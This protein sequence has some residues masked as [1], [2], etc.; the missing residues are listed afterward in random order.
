MAARDWFKRKTKPAERDIGSLEE[1]ASY[2]NQF[3]LDGNTYSLTGVG[4]TQT[5]DGSP[6]E[7][8]TNNLE[9]YALNAYNANGAVFA[10]MAVR[11][12]VFSAIEFQ[13]QNRKTRDLFG[14]PDL[15]PLEEPYKGGTTQDMLVRMIQDAD[16][17][18]N[19]YWT[20][21][22]DGDMLRLRPDW[23]TIALEPRIFRGGVM[24]YRRVGYGY[25]EGGIGVCRSPIPLLLDEVA[26]FAPYPDPLATYRGM[27]WLTPVMREIQSDQQM[28]DHKSKYF[29]NAATPNM[30]ASLPETMGLEDFKKFMDVFNSAHQ[31]VQ[32]AYKTLFLGGGADVT[33]VGSDMQQMSFKTVQGHGE[34][35]IAAAAGVPPIIVG[36][37]EG[38]EAATYSNYSQ[39]RRRLADG[40][41]HPLWQNAAGSLSPLI[42]PQLGSRL[43]YDARHIPFLREDAHDAA[44]IQ[45]VKAST[46][47]QLV[48]AGYKP[49]TVISAVDTED[50]T[51]LVHSG[52]FS[53]Q[54]QPAGTLAKPVQPGAP[55]PKAITGGGGKP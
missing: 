26:H 5:M 8:I 9:Q 34:T 24:G 27:S 47:R 12:L 28:N 13:Y 42:K 21:A 6:Y 4:A 50:M 14:T 38:L 19:S 49:E 23:V 17:A 51:K 29:A 10:C 22:I 54:L 45:R 7:R 3:V 30:V 53:V 31:G 35:R 43:W 11:M 36:L 55:A 18:G 39:A 46:I 1:Y 32:N 41:M 15:S 16:L 2:L 48:D 33:V 40:T 25:H 20:R 52:L 37:S 44:E